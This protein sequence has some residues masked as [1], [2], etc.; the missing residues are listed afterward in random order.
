M[1]SKNI[2]EAL[3][4]NQPE[5]RRLLGH[6]RRLRRAARPDQGL[7]GAHRQAGRQLR[8]G[9]RPQRGHGLEARHQPRPQPAVDQ[10]RHPVRAA[11]PVRDRQVAGRRGRRLGPDPGVGVARERTAQLRTVEDGVPPP[12]RVAIY[13]NP[14][15]RAVFYQ[16]VLL[17]AVLW[18]GYEFALNARANLDAHKITSGFGFLENTAGF[19]INQTLIPYSE[20]DTYGRVFL[21]GP[22]QHAAGLRDRHRAR[23]HPRVHRR[24]RAA[25]AQLAAGAARRRL[26]RADPQPAAPVP[27]PV[28]VSRRARHVAGTAPEHRDRLAAGADARCRVPRRA[29]ASW[30][31]LRPRAV[32]PR[33]GRMGRAAGDLSQQSRHHHAAAGLR[34]GWR[35]RRGCAV[36][37]GAGRGRAARLGGRRQASDRRAVPGGLGQRSA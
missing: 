16:L 8:R 25:V 23:D 35:I 22:A 5:I 15:V 28:L 30:L 33:S 21:V 34:P 13:N 24:H 9:V 19:G 27:D 10:G 32:E 18:F 7:G 6:R 4:S 20:S 2:D 31:V 17:A 37:R 11:D 14:K 12:P 29:R 1:S 26:C 3:K 36:D